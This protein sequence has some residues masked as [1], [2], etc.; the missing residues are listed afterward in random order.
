M[1]PGPAS[2]VVLIT[3]AGDLQSMVRALERER[4]LAVDTESNSL[5][6]YRE[7]VCLIQF[8]TAQADY[9]VDPLA[10]EDL[11]ALSP[12]FGNPEIEKVFHAAEYD[13]LCLRR[14][15]GMEVTNLF[16]TMIAGRILGRNEIGLGSMLEAELG[17]KLDKR[18]Q[19]AN[20]GQRPLPEHLIDYARLD[21]HYLI[22]LRD[23]LHAELNERGLLPLAQEDFRM[24][25][26]KTYLNKSAN[27]ATGGEPSVRGIP[28]RPGERRR[29]AGGLL[30]DQR[31]VRST[32]S[33]GGG[34]DR[35]VPLPRRDCPQAGPPAV[36]SVQ[37][38]DFAGDRQRAAQQAGRAARAAW[39]EPQPGA[40]ARAA[41]AASRPEGAAGAAGL[42]GA[43]AAPRRALH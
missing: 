34:A 3:Q 9:L 25:T 31:I 37:R 17:V 12:L 8:S 26:D 35:I 6:A 2:D 14:D 27:N 40:P 29:E 43:A 16:D 39:D 33:T 22:L 13:L 11:S 32:G 15:F 7:R 18:Y 23:R 36:Q 41:A 21:T 5:H 20:W 4:I 19:R 28:E 30:A 42:P 38:P 1:I 10:L 24:A